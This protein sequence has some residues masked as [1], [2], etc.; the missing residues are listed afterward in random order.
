MNLFY[1][2]ITSNDSECLVPTSWTLILD[3]F[4]LFFLAGITSE[5]QFT[6]QSLILAILHEVV[7]ME[8]GR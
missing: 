2:F 6:K 7:F 5:Q 3:F 8:K 1:Y 4:Y